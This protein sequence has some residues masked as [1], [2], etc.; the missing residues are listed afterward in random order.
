M[1][2]V[3]STPTGEGLVTPRPAT[4]RDARP[5]QDDEDNGGY[6]PGGDL[7]PSSVPDGGSGA[8][9]GFMPERGGS[10]NH[11]QFVPAGAYGANL[12]A[13]SQ[14][15]VKKDENYRLYVR[16]EDSGSEEEWSTVARWAGDPTRPAAGRDRGQQEDGRGE[17]PQSA[18]VHRHQRDQQA[19]APGQTI[20]P[21]ATRNTPIVGSENVQLR[22][23]VTGV[24]EEL[25]AG[26]D[27]TFAGQNLT[28]LIPSGA[29]HT[30]IIDYVTQGD[31]VRRSERLQWELGHPVTVTFGLVFEVL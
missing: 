4:P 8:E 22:D 13:V 14:E 3:P 6:A 29:A 31:R 15:G 12:N 24:N 23:N 19:G 11:P 5:P 10:D 16:R 27:Y 28:V 30:I 26:V 17:I 9:G 25:A 2:G 20:F 18:I 1:P 7:H 21:N